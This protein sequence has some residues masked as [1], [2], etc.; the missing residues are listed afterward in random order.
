MMGREQQMQSAA[1]R[2]HKRQIP[3]PDGTG[4]SCSGSTDLAFL[5]LPFLF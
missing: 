1:L 4:H 3:Q 5:V 2:S